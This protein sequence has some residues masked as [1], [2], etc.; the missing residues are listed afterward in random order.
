LLN[1]NKYFGIYN[2]FIRYNI[3]TIKY[4]YFIENNDII[5]NNEDKTINY[6][7]IHKILKNNE[8][9]KNLNLNDYTLSLSNNYLI[10]YQLISIIILLINYDLKITHN[11]IK[12]YIK[13]NFIINENNF[14]LN[15]IKQILI[16]LNKPKLVN[17]FNDDKKISYYNIKKKI[18]MEIRNNLMI[19]KYQDNYILFE[20]VLVLINSNFYNVK[21]INEYSYKEIKFIKFTYY[22]IYYYLNNIINEKSFKNKIYLIQ[23]FIIYII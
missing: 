19:N 11:L 8:N 17:P 9:N 4:L 18:L 5:N 13:S 14:I 16:N 15:K 7:L 2:S 21:D 6:L 23:K 10:I 20:S 3:S 1:Q 22:F 12:L